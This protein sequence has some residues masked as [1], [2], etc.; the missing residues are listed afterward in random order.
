M[1]QPDAYHGFSGRRRLAL[2]EC[3]HAIERLLGPGVIEWLLVAGE[4]S[5]AFVKLTGVLGWDPSD[6]EAR[7]ARERIMADAR[8]RHLL[9]TLPRWGIDSFSGHDSPRFLP[10][11]LA[12]LHDLGVRAGDH[13]ALDQ[14]LEDLVSHQDDR[15]HFQSRWSFRSGEPSWRALPCDT[16]AITEVLLR[17][18][19][20]SDPRVQRAIA[21]A[22][23]AIGQ[24]PQGRG[25]RCT[26]DPGSRFRGPGRVA[27]LCPQ[28]T[29][30]GLRL[31]AHVPAH[32]RPA[33]LADVARAA[34]AVWRRRASER[35]YQ[36][37]HGYQFKSV[38]WP[39]L[40][41]DVLA[42]V[43]ALGPYP[44]VWGAPGA[45]DEDRAAVAELVA[46]LIAYNTD[47]QGRIVPQRTYRGFEA[48]S[49]GRKGAPSPTATAIVAAALVP[50]V[51]LADD[52]LSVDVAALGSS[53]GG[54]GTA[55]P[56][57]RPW[58]PL[59]GTTAES[60][61]CPAPA[62]TSAYPAEAAVA[63]VLARHH[64]TTPW[65][66][67][68]VESVV[69]DLAAV[70]A[71]ELVAAHLALRARSVVAEPSRLEAALFER[72]SLALFR[73]MR[74][75]LF[76]VRPEALPVIAAATGRAVRQPRRHAATLR[77]HRRRGPRASR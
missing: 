16:L 76:V 10:N 57:R 14:A 55:R 18:G 52:V 72:R 9:E 27:D 46:C 54:T 37:G 44:E 63:R 26:P 25:W 43:R 6:G 42:V 12:I 15:G 49:F 36:F 47:E 28:A 70:R 40:W 7:A 65:V 35:P 67:A 73:G 21:A 34:I 60:S 11:A 30:E 5:A 32:E 68:S 77:A 29:L 66:P 39:D 58:L 23:R 1:A 22:A 41:Y 64:L 61:P 53:K 50:F 75:D 3:L 4:P 19:R 8:I 59:T 38:K 2:E 62:T 69:G 13:P 31:F 51:V 33:R 74:G 24:T 56:P 17:Y 48:F 20:A 45:A 71:N